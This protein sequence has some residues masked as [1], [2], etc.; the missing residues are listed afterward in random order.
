MSEIY[1]NFSISK[2]RNGD[3]IALSKYRKG[4]ND[5][6]RDNGKY[7]NGPIGKFPYRC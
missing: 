6:N 2:Y 5:P 3:P 4:F 7:R 1:R